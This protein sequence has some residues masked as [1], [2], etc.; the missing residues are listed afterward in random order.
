MKR[1][2]ILLI[3]LLCIVM[4]AITKTSKENFTKENLF[5]FLTHNFKD[6]FIDTLQRNSDS[7]YIVLFDKNA[8]KNYK[9]TDFNVQLTERHLDWSYDSMGGHTM[10]IDYFHNNDIRN[11][12]YIWIIENDVYFPGTFKELADIHSRYDHDLLV[13]E[14]G[15]RPAD[16][17][18]QNTLSGFSKVENIGVIGSCMRFSNRLASSLYENR[19]RGYFEIFL[20]HFCIEQGFTI[21]QFMAEFIGVYF[22]SPT[23]LTPL[24][25][26][27][28]KNKTTK[29]VENKLYHPIKI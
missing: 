10:Y 16:W 27:D 26:S 9:E 14:Y 7:D 23:K 12:K 22:T 8:Q 1:V 6:T 2:F 21:Q 13:V 3:I 11:Y 19:D 4:L 28:I 25:E 17:P 20:N 18:W 29:Y 15:T 5:I 24:I